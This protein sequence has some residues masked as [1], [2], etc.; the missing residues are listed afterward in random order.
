MIP[1]CYAFMNRRREKEYNVVLKAIKKEAKIHNLEL[2]PLYIM[3]DYELASINAFKNNFENIQSKGC[4]FHL[5]QN[6][7]KKLVNF[8]LKSEYQANENFATWF[9]SI[10]CLALVPIDKTDQLFESILASKPSIND[11]D[12]FL[13]YLD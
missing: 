3:T 8:G 7:M 1:C 9:R 6:M 12:K 11:V 5:C 4:L 10:C 13:D 2:N